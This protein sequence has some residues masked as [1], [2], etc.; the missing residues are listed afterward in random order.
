[1]KQFRICNAS[2]QCLRCSNHAVLMEP[3]FAML[4]PTFRL[5]PL[6]LSTAHPEA[7]SLSY[8]DNTA[9]KVV[10]TEE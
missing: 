5:K 3:L 7:S 6:H 4:Q 8:T 10:S 1:M 9:M 2:E